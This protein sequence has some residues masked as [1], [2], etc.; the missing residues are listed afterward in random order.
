M[1][2]L[3]TPGWWEIR[4]YAHDNLKLTRRALTLLVA[5]L[6]GARLDCHALA[7][8]RAGEDIHSK[9][10]E[11]EVVP[12]VVNVCAVA[13]YWGCLELIQPRILSVLKA[14][15]AYWK[16]VGELPHEHLRLAEKLEDA[17]IYRDALRHM[18]A[19]AHQNGRWD[20]VATATG[21]TTEELR[22][23][24]TPQLMGL[25]PKTQALRE[26][27]QTLQLGYV[28]AQYYT[29]FWHKAHMRLSDLL[30]AKGEHKVPR[31]VQWVGGAMFS[32]YLT[33]QISG[34]KFVGD[35]FRVDKAG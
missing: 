24:Y 20:F 31:H 7:Q 14:S 6:Y 17:E 10:L 27:L 3:A 1:S 35:N 8:C 34:E 15:P 26:E 33:S 5:L 12:L 18:I 11:W 16:Y 29:G 21:W 25:G 9:C 30:S 2:I 32:E 19:Y 13:E 22:E 28:R 23:Y 4:A